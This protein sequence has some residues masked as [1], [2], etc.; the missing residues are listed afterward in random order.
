MKNT[1][2]FLILVCAA[3]GSCFSQTFKITGKVVNTNNELIPFANVLLLNASD[4]TFVKGTSASEEG[5]FEFLEIEP[6]LYLLQASY[7]GRGSKPLALDIKKDVSLGALIIPSETENLDEVVVTARRPTIKRLSDRLVFN[8]ENTVASQGSSWDIL[9]NTPGV[10]VNQDDLQ[11]RGKTATVYLNDRKVQLS[12]QEVQEL[13]LGL[14]GGVVK[15][16]EVIANPPARYD[17]E[18]GP[19][20]NIVTSKNIIPGYKGSVNGSFTQAVF[21]KYNFGTSHYFKTDKLSVFANYSVSPKKELRKTAKGINYINDT[22]TV[23]S[24]W[25]INN[26]EV[27]E[28]TAQN[29]TVI[30][31]YT[32]D[33]KNSLNFTSNLSFNPNQVVRK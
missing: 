31:D 11:I 23:F 16:I 20:L 7:I 1:L 2:L 18:S 17:A 33:D 19:I 14:S 25:S 13:L 9:R 27:K 24:I 28:T 8:V 32:F 15:S 30:L 29:G 4:S 6:D 10:I 12:G 22:D 3:F 21:P 26:D 5:V